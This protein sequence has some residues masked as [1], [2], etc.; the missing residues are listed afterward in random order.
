MAP[1]GG[2]EGSPRPRVT[3]AALCILIGSMLIVPAPVRADHDS[4]VEVDAACESETEDLWRH[5]S[6]VAEIDCHGSQSAATH[7]IPLVQVSCEWWAH[8]EIVGPPAQEER[9]VVTETVVNATL[10][11]L[12]DPMADWFYDQT[13]PWLDS[14][15][16]GDG[17]VCPEDRDGWVKQVAD[18]AVCRFPRPDDLIRDCGSPIPPMSPTIELPPYPPIH[19]GG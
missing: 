19:D 16:W 8:I 5:V 17:S 2:T 12:H 18:D 9:C 13:C 4:P 10:A 1:S 6:D 14:E 3:I 15:G 11:W 7:P